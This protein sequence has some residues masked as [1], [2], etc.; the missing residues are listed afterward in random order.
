MVDSTDPSTAPR[1]D[2]DAVRTP[3]V[4]QS[5][6]TQLIPGAD[7]VDP[8]T[9]AGSVP[10]ATGITPRMRIGHSKWFNLLWLLTIGFVVLIAAMAA[11][12]HLR[13]LSSVQVF[14]EQHPGVGEVRPGETSAL[15]AWLGAQ[16]FLNLF[17]M[18]FIIRSG[19]QVLTDHPR[20][21]WTRHSTAGREWFHI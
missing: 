16:H 11:A 2:P 15:P 19:I 20:L 4:A 10:Y 1:A 9:W 12:Q 17:L 18:V 3:T 21:Y 6:R 14:I 8:V 5:F 7:V 13:G